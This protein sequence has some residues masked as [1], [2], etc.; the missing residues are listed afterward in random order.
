MGRAWGL[1]GA[2]AWD[3]PSPPT[4][5]GPSAVLHL[6]PEHP[7]RGDAD[8]H[9]RTCTYMQADTHA[10]PE[11]LTFAQPSM[12]ARR[13][14]RMR[15][16]TQPRACTKTRTC[17]HTCPHT[18]AH[19]ALPHPLTHSEHLSPLPRH[20]QRPTRVQ[21]P[22][23]HPPRSQTPAPG[24]ATGPRTW[25]HPSI[26]PVALPAPPA[27]VSRCLRLCGPSCPAPVTSP[28]S[29]QLHGAPGPFPPPPAPELPGLPHTVPWAQSRDSCQGGGDSDTGRPRAQLLGGGGVLWRPNHPPPRGA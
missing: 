24:R 14:A 10:H 3:A 22:D 16:H 18:H 21:P 28:P 12:C 4:R 8:T 6:C 26:H 29:R 23:T 11:S 15:M 13:Y 27:I 9:T 20:T 19:S 5:Q 17:T 25:V 1:A 2:G 7:W